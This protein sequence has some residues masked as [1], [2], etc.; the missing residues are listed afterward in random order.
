MDAMTI[1]PLAKAA[2]VSLTA[3]TMLATVSFVMSKA[4][5][6]HVA[7]ESSQA[8]Q[9]GLLPLS[10]LIPEKTKVLA[11]QAIAKYR[12]VKPLRAS[13][14]FH[15]WRFKALESTY[16]VNRELQIDMDQIL[17]RSDFRRT[18]PG[19]APL[20]FRSPYGWEV[21]QR[22]AP[23]ARKHWEYEHHVDQFLA[24][25]AEIGAPLNLS[26]ETD[27]GRV[28]I[29][30]L[31]EASRRNCDSSQ[32]ACWT[33]VA[34][35]TYLPEELQWRNRFGELCSYESMVEGILSLPPD[36]GSC[37]GTHKQFALAHFLNCP[38]S[39]HWNKGLRRQCEEYLCHSSRLLERSQ[40]P[41]GAWSPQWAKE[42]A[43]IV[44]IGGSA[45]IRGA[46]LIR[47]TG[48]HLEWIGIAPA[49]TCPSTACASHALLFMAEALNQVGEASIQGDYCAYSH[50]ACVLQRALV[51]DPSGLRSLGAS[52]A[53][54]PQVIS[55]HFLTTSEG[56]QAAAQTP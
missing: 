31:L 47:I 42:P 29:S 23:Y 10:S 8:D 12:S 13:D 54:Q 9:G 38:S 37:G 33:L 7:K 39:R 27:S 43:E 1:S 2:L 24:T 41:N 17:M 40:L 5:S 16:S 15:R 6:E 14:H 34:Y 53:A 11:S 52:S 22:S 36:T 55:S 56:S 25:C 50:A 45:S 44:D 26:I 19:S 35:C 21:R 28:T 3:T 48:H 46:D 20:F 49:A 51:S 30:E 18:F 4:R 32:D